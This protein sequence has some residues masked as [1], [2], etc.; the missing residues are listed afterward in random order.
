MEQH[1]DD[2]FAEMTA[3]AEYIDPL[4]W[5]QIRMAR[6]AVR[7]GTCAHWDGGDTDYGRCQKR[8]RSEFGHTYK[9]VTY[10]HDRCDEHEFDGGG[11]KGEGDE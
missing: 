2:V 9:V 1:D 6:R 4:L 10:S 3:F 5:E 11:E 7:C 8:T